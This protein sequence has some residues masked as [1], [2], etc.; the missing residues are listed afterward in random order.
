MKSNVQQNIPKHNI[1]CLVL[2]ILFKFNTAKCQGK[3]NSCFSEILFSFL[4]I[5]LLSDKLWHLHLPRQCSTNK[6]EIDTFQN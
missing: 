2:L 5:C 3:V 4:R 6:L 1:P